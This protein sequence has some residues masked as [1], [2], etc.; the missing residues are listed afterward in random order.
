MTIYEPFMPTTDEFIA[1]KLELAQI[2]P[3][4]RVFDLGCGDARVLIRAALDFRANCVGY[5]IRPDLF[6]TA[7][8]AI[9]ESDLEQRVKIVRGNFLQADVSSADVV[10]LYLS[11]ES[12]AP[13][14]AKF[15]SELPTGARIVCHTFGLPGWIPKKHLRVQ[16]AGRH[17][18][19]VFL[20]VA[21]VSA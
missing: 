9:R 18:D 14:A 12:I 1:V 19:E 10:V 4:E 2:Q 11:K 7:L 20:Y 15:R 3:E 5:E 8:E 17:I 16:T 21:G 6:E 13:L